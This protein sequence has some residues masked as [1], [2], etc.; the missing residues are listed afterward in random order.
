[1][2]R[3]RGVAYLSALITDSL[4]SRSAVRNLPLHLLHLL[5][6]RRRRR[7]VIASLI[8]SGRDPAHF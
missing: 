6:R 5:L 1:M 2:G 8:K 7:V 4:D 3:H